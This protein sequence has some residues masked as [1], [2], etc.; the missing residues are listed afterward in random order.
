MQDLYAVLGVSR[1]ASK[2]EIKKV[3]RKL[4][5]K[6]HPDKNAGKSAAE[7]FKRVA[8]AYQVLGDDEKRKLYDEF[9]ADSLR[10]G[11]DAKA[12]RAAKQF[13][14]FGRGGGRGGAPIDL[15]DIFGA[16]GGGAGGGF[17]DLFGEIFGGRPGAQQGRR[18]QGRKGQ[19]LQTQVTLEFLDAIRGT[20]VQ[21]RLSGQPEPISV[22]VPAG[23]VDGGKMRVRGRGQ[24]GQFGGPSGDLLLQLR[25]KDH[26]H[27]RRDGDN[28]HLE[29]PLTLREA[30]EGAQVTV[31]TPQGDVKLRVPAGTQSGQK[32]RLR[33]KGVTRKNK[34]SGDLYVRFL[35]MYPA[36]DKLEELIGE[37]PEQEDPRSK[38]RL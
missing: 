18:Q 14:G 4:A 36:D 27:F 16:T 3:Y 29:L 31:P 38:L 12:A 33:S 34:P 2:Q 5:S 26:K 7:R 11:F 1:T 15:N 20:T 21:L 28:L 19:D 8:A 9:G 17:G 30:Y 10:V 23:V 25:V 37:L 24:P 35:V 22:R 13:G 6:L 32:L